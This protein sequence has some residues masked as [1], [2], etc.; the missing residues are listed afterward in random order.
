MLLYEI[1]KHMN[2]KILRKINEY[3]SPSSL[4]SPP[5]RGRHKSGAVPAYLDSP[6]TPGHWS[7][8]VQRAVY[9]GGEEMTLVTVVQDPI[10]LQS[11][12]LYFCIS[13]LLGCY[14]EGEGIVLLSEWTL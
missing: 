1:E 7:L 6:G 11:T 2:A 12:E 4:S 8:T 3:H 5:I 10:S 14:T 9:V 13:T